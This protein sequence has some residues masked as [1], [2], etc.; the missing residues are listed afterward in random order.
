MLYHWTTQSYSNSDFKTNFIYISEIKGKNGNIFFEN[1][2]FRD[3][4]IFIWSLQAPK[5]QVPLYLYIYQDRE[6]PVIFTPLLLWCYYLVVANCFAQCANM[7][8]LLLYSVFSTQNPL[9]SRLFTTCRNY[10]FT[11]SGFYGDPKLE[12]LVRHPGHHFGWRSRLFVP[13]L[14]CLMNRRPK[15]GISLKWNWQLLIT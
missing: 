7:I 15:V 12:S 11:G 14:P 5:S 6:I 4:S 3:W 2:N 13:Q 10:T 9:I 8:V 1:H